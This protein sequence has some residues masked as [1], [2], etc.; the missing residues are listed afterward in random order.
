MVVKEDRT[1]MKVKRT[2]IQT[3]QEDVEEVDLKATLKGM[4]NLKFNVIAATNMVIINLSVEN[5]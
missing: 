3:H 2:K 5:S 1:T 4:T